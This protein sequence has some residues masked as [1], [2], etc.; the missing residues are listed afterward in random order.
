MRSV[1][2]GAGI[3]ARRA[4]RALVAARHAPA[5]L[6]SVQELSGYES[7][8][9]IRASIYCLKEHREL[10]FAASETDACVAWLADVAAGTRLFT[11]VLPVA[12]YTRTPWQRR[13]YRWT[14]LAAHLAHLREQGGA[15]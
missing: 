8:P 1:V 9:I 3:A 7:I 10:T 15:A 13:N 11:C 6:A 2:S 12:E 5:D 14:S 4:L